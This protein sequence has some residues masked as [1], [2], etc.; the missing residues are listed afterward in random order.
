MF[1]D[2]KE[3]LKSRYEALYGESSG[4]EKA[5]KD[6]RKLKGYLAL[7]F[8]GLVALVAVTI[9]G[10]RTSSINMDVNSKGELVK[11]ARPSK[12]QG[13]AVIDSS[14]EAVGK[15][16]S[17]VVAKEIVIDP[18]GSRAEKEESEGVMGEESE[19]DRLKRKIDTAVRELNDGTGGKNVVLPTT[20]DDG[21]KLVWKR[22]R[23]SNI[24]III[25]AFIFLGVAV[26][27]GRFSNLKK[28]E[29]MARDSVMRELPEFINKTVLLLQG[30]VVISDALMRIINDRRSIGT[31]SY[32]Y[33][34]L[35]AIQSR[36]IQ[37]NSPMHEELSLFA[38]R[39]GVREL[40]RVS[41]IINDNIDKGADLTGKLS[42][43]SSLLWFARKK[44]A[45]EKG[46]IAETKLTL[47]LV[48][49]ILVLV[50]ITVAPALLEI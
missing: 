10:E 14:V 8:I 9:V 45:E 42:A 17:V 18:A 29:A 41:N 4:V 35:Y 6:Y 16:G 27:A 22:E 28:E 44:Q 13:S 30:G 5:E 2:N 12:E 34:Q 11:I 50:M 47:P 38:K 19:S 31:D 15:K 23:K 32:F 3:I 36:V 43:E 39:S 48:I 26:Y 20:L 24:P 46:R 40:M 21:T 7:T 1:K 37:T 25:I 49:L 33:N